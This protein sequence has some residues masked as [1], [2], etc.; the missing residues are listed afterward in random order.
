PYFEDTEKLLDQGDFSV[1]A[2]ADLRHCDILARLCVGPER[3][4]SGACRGQLLLLEA[5]KTR[6]CVASL[7]GKRHRT[8]CVIPRAL[9]G[10]LAL[11]FP[12]ALT[13]CDRLSL[14][15]LFVNPL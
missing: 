7:R 11:T 6:R 12:L 1:L 10:Q 14:N 4:D 2:Q 5:P 13:F 8:H 9:H 15:V 3:V